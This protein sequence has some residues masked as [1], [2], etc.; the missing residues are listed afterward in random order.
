MERKEGST[1]TLMVIEASSQQSRAAVNVHNDAMCC[2]IK[3]FIRK[4]DGLGLK[5]LEL[6]TMIPTD[7]FFHILMSITGRIQTDCEPHAITRKMLFSRE[8]HTKII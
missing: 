7:Y 2:E 3:R 1:A 6:C 8:C 4:M 5:Y